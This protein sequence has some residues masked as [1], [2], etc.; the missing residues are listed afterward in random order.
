LIRASFAQQYPYY[1]FNDHTQDWREFC[2]LLASLSERTPLGRIVMIRSEDDEEM[3]K[4]FS[5]GMLAERARWRTS[6]MTDSS[7][8][9][10]E[11]SGAQAKL[12]A[13]LESMAQ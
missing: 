4:T 5:P 3:L 2:D 9:E 1:D 6:H 12:F 10:E 8:N 11:I 7:M 13:A